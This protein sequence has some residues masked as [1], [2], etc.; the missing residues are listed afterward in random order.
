MLNDKFECK[1][2][3]FPS[4]SREYFKGGFDGAITVACWPEQYEPVTQL[5]YSQDA[6]N[7]NIYGT[8]GIHP[9][10]ADQFNEKIK[11]QIIELVQNDR[12]RKRRKI[13]AVGECGLDFSHPNNA[14]KEIQK[15]TFK[16]QI[17]LSVQLDLPLVVHSREA[18]E[19]TVEMMR[20]YCPRDK[21]VHLHC[22]TDSVEFAKTML[23][24]FPK[25]KIGFTG[26]ILFKKADDKRETVKQVP[27]DR[28]L[29]ETDSPF[30]TP[31]I[32]CGCI[33]KLAEK[34]AELHGISDVNDVLAQC[35]KNTKEIYGV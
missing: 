18:V 25:L 33:P 10:I 2:D 6:A 5:I 4:V 7:T 22:F 28:I 32:H 14:E 8:F 30:F 31:A 26:S 17:E 34:I 19:D 27:L 16:E 12:K 24:E 29:L 1:V 11:R 9:R 21:L 13:V 23:A 35:R 3:D 20:K 15:Q